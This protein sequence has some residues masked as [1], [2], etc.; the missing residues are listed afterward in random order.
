MAIQ[1]KFHLARFKPVFNGAAHADAFDHGDVLFDWHALEIPRGGCA[2]RSVTA[3]VQGTDGAAANDKNF[4]LVFAKSIDGVAPPALPVSNA[5]FASSTSVKV[6]KHIIGYKF[7]AITETRSTDNEFRAYSLIT[8]GMADKDT[9]ITG[10]FSTTVTT[11]AGMT[12]GFSPIILEGDPS[13]SGTTKGYQTIWVAGI[14]AEGGANFGTGI[15]IDEGSDYAADSTATL[16]CDG[17]NGTLVLAPGDELVAQDGAVIGTVKSV[18]YGA[19]HTTITLES[20]VAS[21]I[22][23]DDE[24]CFKS[25]IE[26]MLGLEY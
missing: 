22:E 1:S 9:Q 6:R 7:L 23:N 2:I 10:D 20:N 16:N 17:T 13:Y 14:T 5:V 21:D 18:S 24:V 19:S 11:G 4:S 25:P 3:I 26:L 8:D 15:L 12:A